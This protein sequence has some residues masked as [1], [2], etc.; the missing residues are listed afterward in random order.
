[1]RILINGSTGYLGNHLSE[2][3]S[4]QGYLIERI[5][6]EKSTQS[7]YYFNLSQEHDYK[8][9]K[10]KFD[11]FIFVAFDF[12]NKDKIEVQSARSKKLINEINTHCRAKVIFIS[13][14]SAHS[15][16]I[17]NYGKIKFSIEQEVIK[18][19]GIIIRPG[20]LFGKQHSTLF[21]KLKKISTFPIIP[22]IGKG[23]Q[24]ICTS[25]IDHILQDIK[26]LT[27]S[28]NLNRGQIFIPSNSQIYSFKQLMSS[29]DLGEKKFIPIPS[30]I[31][32]LILLFLKTFKVKFLFDHDNLLGLINEENEKH[33]FLIKSNFIQKLT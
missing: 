13:S 6:K 30:F 9:P 22:I 8:L 3:L 28:F 31:I 33:I 11:F 26:D 18:L 7:Q 2:Y 20:L 24:I 21:I 1:M 23:N 4:Q 32:K 12:D 10:E 29:F 15:N 17:S 14:L 27:L 25:S 19:N 5:S 16:T